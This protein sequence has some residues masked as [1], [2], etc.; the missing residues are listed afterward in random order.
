M[1]LEPGLAYSRTLALTQRFPTKV[2][3]VGQDGDAF[4]LRVTGPD[5]TAESLS[6]FTPKCHAN[7]SLCVVT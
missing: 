1:V 7:V 2:A 5:R 6:L 3:Y 4:N